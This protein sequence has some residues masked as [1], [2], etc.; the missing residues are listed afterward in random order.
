MAELVL[1][2]D[3]RV[4]AVGMRDCGEPLVDLRSIDGLKVDGRQADAA[5]WY[6]MAR[7]GTA[8]RLRVAERA[9]P[10]GYRLV[11]VEAYRPVALQRRYFDEHVAYLRGRHS[12]WSAERLRRE[13]SR[14]VSQEELAPH[15]TGGAVDVTLRGPDSRLCWMGTE[16]NALPGESDDACHTEAVNVSAVSRAN[17]STLGAAMLTAGFVNHPAEWWHWSIGDQYWAFTTSAA[18]A[19][20]GAV[21]DTRA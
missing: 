10:V 18:F 14:Y 6:A 13:A 15:T 9:L 11:V 17:R 5:G 4:A 3:E 20:Y 12:S 16:V 2:G 19:W 1:L 21:T 8:Q 7:S